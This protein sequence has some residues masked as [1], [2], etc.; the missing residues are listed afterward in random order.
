MVLLSWSTA[1]FSGMNL[2]LLKCFGEIIKQGDFSSLPI[3]TSCLLVFA[4]SG[5]IIQIVMLNIGLKYYNNIDLMPVYQ[6]LILVMMLACGWVLLDEISCYSWT[7]VLGI[8]GSACLIIIGI[9]I[10]TIK[11]E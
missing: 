7:Q 10:I 9:K 2:T 3:M 8:L 5:A 11:P 1:T 4:V 6:S